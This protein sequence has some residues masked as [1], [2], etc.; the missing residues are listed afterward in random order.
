MAGGSIF[1]G[2]RLNVWLAESLMD[3]CVWL[4]M[5]NENVRVASQ[6]RCYLNLLGVL[7]A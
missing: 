6:G 4:Q 2:V 1:D 3:T 5:E 7:Q